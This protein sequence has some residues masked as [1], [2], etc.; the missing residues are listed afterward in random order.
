MCKKGVCH[1]LDQF[2]CLEGLSLFEIIGQVTESNVLYNVVQSDR[3]SFMFT[4]SLYSLESHSVQSPSMVSLSCWR[5]C[6][7]L[8]NIF[9]W[10]K[11]FCKHNFSTG[12]TFLCGTQLV[13]HCYIYCMRKAVTS[14]C[15]PCGLSVLF[16]H[17]THFF[18]FYSYKVLFSV[19][20]NWFMLSVRISS[21]GCTREVWRA[22]RE[23]S[24]RVAR[25]IA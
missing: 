20:K 15:R 8:C 13:D 21:Y 12:M 2:S 5:N 14:K 16:L 10:R 19:F 9:P 18:Q 7:F 1:I 4:V 3:S 24:V 11:S 17:L 25:G 22:Q 23:R 6:F